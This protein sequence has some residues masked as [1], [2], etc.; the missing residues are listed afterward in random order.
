MRAIAFVLLAACAA[1]PPA[2]Q[3]PVA[4]QS[5]P[6]QPGP[7][8]Q[9]EAD[10]AIKVARE[11]QARLDQIAR[12]LAALDTKLAD[13]AAQIDKAQS[14]ATRSAASA[15]LDELLREQAEAFRRLRDAKDAVEKARSKG[16]RDSTQCENNPLAKGC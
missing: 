11:A 9:Q 14:D 13:L 7:T 12:D 5:P 4:N 6:A 15:R 16:D 10:E 8:P 2:P 3:A 1:D